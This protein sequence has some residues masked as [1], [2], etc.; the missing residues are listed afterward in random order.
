MSPTKNTSILTPAQRKRTTVPAKKAAANPTA[1]IL[2]SAPVVAKASASL[3]ESIVSIG[4][5][6]EA[7]ERA[8]VSLWDRMATFRRYFPADPSTRAILGEDSPDL[9]GRTSE[10]KAAWGKVLDAARISLTERYVSEWGMNPIAAEKSARDA[11]EKYR[12]SASVRY[13]NALENNVRATI[14]T[15]AGRARFMLAHGFNYQSNVNDSESAPMCIPAKDSALKDGKLVIPG[16]VVN[17]KTGAVTVAKKSLTAGNQQGQGTGGDTVKTAAAALATQ[18]ADHAT[19]HDF[20]GLIGDAQSVLATIL[21]TTIPDSID[22]ATRARALVEIE[23]ALIKVRDHAGIS[24]EA[25]RAARNFKPGTAPAAKSQSEEE[26]AEAFAVKL[27]AELD[28]AAS[29]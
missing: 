18:F 11:T 17:E 29:K 7:G 4:F 12:K 9:V 2:A 8:E 6:Q 13:R 19:K 5:H 26:K 22:V 20:V 15:P 21:S 23:R 28:A 16:Y 10:Y 14:D 25:Y 1:L 27:Q 24:P 3:A